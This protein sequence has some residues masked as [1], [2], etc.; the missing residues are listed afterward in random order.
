MILKP[1][2]FL[3]DL[4]YTAKTQY[5]KFEK[6]FPKKLRGYCPNFQIHASVSDL[7]ISLIGLPTLLQ[8]NRWNK[9]ENTYIDHSQTYTVKK[10]FASFPSPAGM[11][12]PNSPWAGIMTS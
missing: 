2:I 5:R 4:F 7:Y 6:I 8:D 1:T 12:L 11:S 10:R 3:I 9:R